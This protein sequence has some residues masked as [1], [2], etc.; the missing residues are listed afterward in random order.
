M[1]RSSEAHVVPELV[2]FP[3]DGNLL[4]SSEEVSPPVR[5]HTNSEQTT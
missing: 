2:T 4:L 1:A 5:N 3:R